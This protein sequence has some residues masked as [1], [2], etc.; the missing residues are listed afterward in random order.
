M[1]F[2]I[3]KDIILRSFSLSLILLPGWIHVFYFKFQWPTG[4]IYILYF[5]L[6]WPPGPII[7]YLLL[8]S[9]PI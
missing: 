5:D 8:K 2:N 6:S 7:H 9:I 1:H 3:A 4:S